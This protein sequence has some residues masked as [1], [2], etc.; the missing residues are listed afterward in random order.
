MG[1]LPLLARDERGTSAIEMALALPIL[2]GLLIGMVD[3]SLGFAAKLHLEQAAQR[4]IEKAMQGTKST[5][6]YD[7]LKVE[8]A[9]AA[10][11]NPSAVVVDYWLECNGA[12]KSDFETNC[13]AGQSYAR[14][15]TVEITKAYTPMFSARF[16]GANADGTYTLRGRAGIRVQ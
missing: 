5:T 15:L 1:P 10:G 12:R 11:V 6:L 9:A 14:Y 4:S 8:G 2:A 7:T 16:A 3:M 13:T